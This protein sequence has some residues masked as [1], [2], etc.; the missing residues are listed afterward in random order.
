[1]NYRNIIAGKLAAYLNLDEDMINKLVEVPPKSDMGDFAFP[2][3]QLSKTIKKSPNLIAIDIKENLGCIDGFE[4]IE[5]LGPY[6]NFFVSKGEFVKEVINKVLEEK[7]DYGHSNDGAGKNVIVEYCSANIAKPF[8]VGHLFTTMLGNS[9]YKIFKFQ[10]YNAIGINHLG[11]WGTQF[12]KLIYAYIHWGDEEA[13]EK[14]PIK[15]MFRVYV[16]FHEEAEKNPCLDDEGRR[17]FKLLEDGNPIEMELWSKFKELSLKEFDRLFKLLNVSFDSFDGESFYTDKMDTVIRE[18]EDKELLTESNGAKV[19]FLDE[20]NMPPC[21]I[22]KADGATIYAT[23]D[24]AAVFYRKKTYDFYKNIYVVAKDQ[25]LHFK[26]VFTTV[27]KMG[28]DW[29][30]DCIHVSFGLVRFPDKKLS[31]RKGNVVFLE[32]LLYEAISKTEEIINDKNPNLENKKEVAK[33]VGIGA[34]VFTYLKNSRERDIV[35][36][37]SEMLSFEGETGPYVQYTYARGKSILRKLG[38]GTD[39]VNYSKLLSNEEFELVKQ[40]SKFNEVVKQALDKLQPSII[41][42]YVIDISKAFNKFYTAINISNF[43]DEI[44]RSSRLNLVKASLQVIK[45]GLSL[46]GLE[47]VDEM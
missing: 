46:I 4:K 11:D 45:N 23:R 14:E 7:D 3:F 10:G 6:I 16:K 22:K 33:K 44:S 43:H 27:K 1:M 17:H 28:Y 25:T 26:Q 8:H 37:W 47:T 42:R 21:I 29:A 15:E 18:L 38:E 12:G 31:T 40:L 39:E 32:D 20:E 35:F 2:C 9:L 41:T 30:D 5:A 19:V 36:D 34:V 13:L 24:L